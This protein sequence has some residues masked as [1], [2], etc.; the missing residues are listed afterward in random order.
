MVFVVGPRFR[1]AD[2]LERLGIDDF[3]GLSLDNLEGSKSSQMDDFILFDANLNGV[4]HCRDCPLRLCLGRLASELLLDSR[5]EF[6]FG[7]GSSLT[8]RASFDHRNCSPWNP[9]GILETGKD[10]VH[11]RTGSFFCRLFQSVSVRGVI[12]RYLLDL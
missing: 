3:P 4:D 9:L 10:L 8:F 6:Y 12:L 11:E 1:D 7:E 5:H 2:L